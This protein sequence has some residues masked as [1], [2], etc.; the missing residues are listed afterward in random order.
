MHVQ[1]EAHVGFRVRRVNRT[2]HSQKIIASS[3]APPWPQPQEQARSGW[4]LDPERLTRI[5]RYGV[6]GSL[7]EH[8][9]DHFLVTV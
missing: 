6:D 7:A 2:R 5:R 3:T 4:Q 8:L 1:L 9:D